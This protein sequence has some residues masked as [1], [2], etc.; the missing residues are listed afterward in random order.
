MLE[1][2]FERCR[3]FVCER[4]E[5]APRRMPW[6]TAPFNVT[7]WVIAR[8]GAPGMAAKVTI[9]LEQGLQLTP[10][11]VAAIEKL[12][13]KEQAAEFDPQALAVLGVANRHLAAFAEALAGAVATE[14]PPLPPPVDPFVKS[15]A[16]GYWAGHC[17]EETPEDY[18][19]RCAEAGRLCVALVARDFR[20]D[21]DVS[22]PVGWWLSGVGYDAVRALT[23][24][25]ATPGAP[26]WRMTRYGLRV[27]DLAQG[28]ARELAEALGAVA[29]AEGTLEAEVDN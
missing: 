27:T 28:P 7:T 22:C 9:D 19:E 2:D 23:K 18:L 6:V 3:L 16:R 14:E 26:H 15:W 13:A 17:N 20:Y 10:G 24:G 29:Q 5:A 1:K 4:G 12:C 25:L 21:V 11:S 8:P